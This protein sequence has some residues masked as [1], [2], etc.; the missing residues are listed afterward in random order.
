[1]AVASKGQTQVTQPE[2]RN[3]AALVSSPVLYCQSYISFSS[4]WLSKILQEVSDQP[5][6]D[7]LK[8]P[9]FC[10]VY[11]TD[12]RKNKHRLVRNHSRSDLSRWLQ[13]LSLKSSSLC[14]MCS[15]VLSFTPSLSSAVL[16]PNSD[17]LCACSHLDLAHKCV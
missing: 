7:A 1:M 4:H 6:Q 16:K 3:S 9:C 2:H 5:H 12:G 14:R 13:Q 11:I 15:S 17:L 8:Y 10:L